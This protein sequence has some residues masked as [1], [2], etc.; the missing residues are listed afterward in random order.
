L[1]ARKWP[2]ISSTPSGSADRHGIVSYSDAGLGNIR[3]TQTQ[4]LCSGGV[5]STYSQQSQGSIPGAGS[6]H[7]NFN[8]SSKAVSV[9]T[10]I[11]VGGRS[12]GFKG[13]FTS[14]W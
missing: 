3:G 1:P 14:P 2:T 4:D 12:V 11:S 9:D 5:N 7:Q 13:G 6:V 8:V 10:G